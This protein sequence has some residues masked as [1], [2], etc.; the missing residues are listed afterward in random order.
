MIAANTKK[1]DDGKNQTSTGDESRDASHP[2]RIGAHATVDETNTVLGVAR[3]HATKNSISALLAHIQIDL[4]DVVVDLR[5]PKKVH[6]EHKPRR[7]SAAQVAWLE[8]EIDRID[9]NLNPPHAFILPG[10]TLFAA[11]L[12]HARAVAYRAERAITALM[13]VET[14]NEQALRYMS[15]LSDFLFVAAREVNGNDDGDLDWGNE[16]AGTEAA[17]RP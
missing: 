17:Q 9:A 13:K 11:H 12:Q 15:R 2:L 10:G 14:V 6:S 8:S 7:V 3:A 16:A 1:Q 5:T 4:F